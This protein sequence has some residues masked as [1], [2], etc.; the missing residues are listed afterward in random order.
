MEEESH[1]VGC[2]YRAFDIYAFLVGGFIFFAFEIRESLVR[3]R[4]QRRQ[5]WVNKALVSY[6]VLCAGGY[7]GFKYIIF[8]L[9][10]L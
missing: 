6:F 4:K 5:E 2:Y 3:L 9:E 7:T 10:F 1:D 8:L